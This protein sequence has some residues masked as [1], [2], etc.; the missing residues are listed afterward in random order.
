M[1]LEKR[2]DFKT[3]A[4]IIA[5][6]SI[7]VKTGEGNPNAVKRE[8]KTGDGTEGVKFELVYNNLRGL[9]KGIEFEDGKY[10]QQM[11]VTIDDI[12]LAVNTDSAW[13]RDIMQK[14]P[15]IDLTKEV[16]FA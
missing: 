4:S 5:D 13:G 12:T 16:T 6:G 8:F 11:F 7:R 14:L 15:A 10:G 3:F 9:I 1:G 2:E